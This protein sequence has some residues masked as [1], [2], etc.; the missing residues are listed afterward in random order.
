MLP[1]KTYVLGGKYHAN[2]VRKRI[3]RT[4]VSKVKLNRLS[5]AEI[6]T[7]TEV[8]LGID[9]IKKGDRVR[10]MVVARTFFTELA[11]LNTKA[12][13]Q[14]IA[15]ALGLKSHATVM[16]MKKNHKNDLLYNDYKYMWEDFLVEVNKELINHFK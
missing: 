16:N 15:K 7:I 13:F 12:S 9:S 8:S 11:L 10:S 2:R 6:R 5:L 3:K 1:T 14:E 4:V